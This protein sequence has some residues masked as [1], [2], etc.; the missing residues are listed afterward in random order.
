MTAGTFPEQSAVLAETR[1]DQVWI[2]ADVPR[3][4]EETCCFLLVIQQSK[5]VGCCPGIQVLTVQGCCVVTPVDMLAVE[6]VNIQTGVWKRRDGRWGESR[7]WRFV[8][9]DDLVSCDVYAQP[10]SL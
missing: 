4:K 1:E 10:L 2:G 5:I 6:V 9:I 3:S 8:D 7:A